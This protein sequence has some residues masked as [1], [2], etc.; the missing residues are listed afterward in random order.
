MFRGQELQDPEVHPASES[1]GT[2]ELAAFTLAEVLGQKPLRT[3]AS[4]A[5]LL[6]RFRH[7]VGM[8]FEGVLFKSLSL[9]V[10]TSPKGAF[11]QHSLGSSF[12]TININIL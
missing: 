3:T 5:P 10:V 4:W 12:P 7:T 2:H 1:K 11:G 9:Q 6:L 8:V